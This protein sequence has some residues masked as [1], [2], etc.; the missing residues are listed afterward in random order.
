MNDGNNDNLPRPAEQ[1]RP[2]PF[3][4]ALTPNDT[5]PRLQEVPRTQLEGRPGLQG[6]RA[7]MRG[8]GMPEGAG[9]G[10]RPLAPQA[11]GG[12]FQTS[13]GLFGS[14]KP[15]DFSILQLSDEQKNRIRSIRRQNAAPVKELQKTLRDQRMTMRDLMFDPNASDEQIRSKRKEIRQMQ[16]RME[17]AQIN[18]FLSIRHVLSPEQRQRLPDLKPG[19]EAQ[20]GP[21][22]GGPPR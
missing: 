18:D 4:G 13:G 12:K 10:R 3:A 17:E 14:K 20:G 2:R 7:R 11:A 19:Q 15:L 21:A 1:Q 8:Q 5:A 9:F 22:D 16:D 6:L